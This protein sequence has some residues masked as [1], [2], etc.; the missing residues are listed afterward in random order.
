MVYKPEPIDTSHVVLGEDILS[1]SDVL[2]K[3][4]HDRWALQRLGE[5]WLPGPNRD[6]ERRE[7]PCLVEYE[8]LPASERAYDHTMVL[9]TL[10]A[11]VALGY[12][13]EPP[14]ADLRPAA[15]APPID[16]EELD[17]AGIVALWRSDDAGLG[18]KLYGRLGERSLRLGEPLIAYDVLEAGLK[19]DPKNVRLRQLQAL[20]LARVG[21]TERASALL[22]ELDR[23]SA[24][25]EETLGLL[26]RTHKDLALRA[27]SGAERTRQLRK[28]Y[29]A[30]A[31]AHARS[32]GYWSGINAASLAVLIGET[33]DAR[34]LAREVRE[35]CRIELEA[36]SPSD[37]YWP[38]ATLGE[39]ALVL[40]E[41]GEAEECYAR[42]AE[43]A[44]GRLGD[45]CSTRR[46]ARLLLEHLRIDPG[47]IEACFHIP[48][49]VV[50][51]GHVIDAPG[52]TIPRFPP[53]LEDATRD[54]LRERLVA[55]DARVGFASAASGADIL[56]HE[57]IRAIGGESTVVLPYGPEQFAA[58]CVDVQPE[59]N[60]GAR[61]LD[62]LARARQVVLAATEKV[63]GQ[64]ASYDYGNLFLLGLARIRAEQLDSRLVP[65]AVWD[66]RRGDAPGGTASV[67]ESWRARGLAVEV[68]DLAAI[69]QREVPGVR[70]VPA[71]HP[72]PATAD[73]DQRGARI[74]AILFADAIHFSHLTESQI[75]SFVSEFLGPIGELVAS[76]TD[77][78]VMKN[79]WG[80][81]L[82]LVFEDVGRAGRFALDLSETIAR[83]D[84]TSKGLPAG[85]S[86][87]IGLH[88]GPVH[89]CIDPVTGRPNYI[90]THVSRG[91]RIE[92][93]T[94]PGQ[95][96][97]SQA[98]AA[99]SAAEG[100]Q[101]FT[102]DYVGQTVWA[103]G[104]GTF[105]TYHVLRTRAESA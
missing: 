61:Y 18:P 2:A 84:W 66:G 72:L 86:L 30:Y 32:G 21:A 9:E 65:L 103:K 33:A 97:A 41:W 14:A 16:A 20:A 51:T 89:E 105:P 29:E 44:R 40:G 52:R 83:T 53:R 100:V 7:H 48:A 31:R 54:A 68:I 57:T 13:L 36:A 85:L 50:F 25:D 34:R 92:P 82:Y 35:R 79:T 26:A 8:A 10:K 71:P 88:A 63:D 104:Y 39:A 101:G 6:D 11:L 17:V 58:D 15:S 24:G 1:L 75:P 3:S 99:L 78:P 43:L 93:I 77:P 76:A 98:F 47:R 42:A 23:E 64:S 28:A 94:P 74:M 87:R 90:G 59:G 60:W 80:D 27:G 38:M 95:V 56:F 19:A 4:A 73:E 69:L 46:N 102:C 55:L 96:Y 91:A 67:V 49:V 70:P 81:G 22:Q 37:P 5:G 45:L 62:V 12:R